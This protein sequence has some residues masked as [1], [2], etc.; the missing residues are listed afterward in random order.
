V[1]EPTLRLELEETTA[2]NKGSATA[3]GAT[4]DAFSCPAVGANWIDAVGLRRPRLSLRVAAAEE[5][6]AMNSP[7][8]GLESND[9][10]RP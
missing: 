2:F 5:N 6:L 10:E 1:A 4:L 8:S 9:P 3:C 7:V